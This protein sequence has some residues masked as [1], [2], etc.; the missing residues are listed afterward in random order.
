MT[1]DLLAAPCRWAASFADDP[2]TIVAL[3]E[4]ALLARERGDSIRAQRALEF[5]VANDV[6][7]A[8]VH[9][10]ARFWQSLGEPYTATLLLRQ[11]VEGRTTV[12]L[13]N[14]L[15][16]LCCAQGQLQDAALWW[17]RAGS[18][19]FARAEPSGRQILH[20]LGA[21]SA[22]FGR[23]AFRSLGVTRASTLLALGR[24]HHEQRWHDFRVA[25]YA[26]TAIDTR[27]GTVRPRWSDVPEFA[28]GN[29]GEADRL[30]GPARASQAL[31]RLAPEGRCGPPSSGR[32]VH[33]VTSLDVGGL[34]LR[35]LR[36]I[37]R[38]S[39]PASHTVVSCQPVL[40]GLHA[41]FLNQCRALGIEVLCLK[42]AG[43]CRDIP[44]SD[45]EQPFDTSTGKELATWFDME[46][47]RV[48][49]RL[50]NR[51][52]PFEV[53]VWGG[54]T[55]SKL[56]P[57]LWLSD[58]PRIRHE[59]GSLLLA[60]EVGLSVSGWARRKFIAALTVSGMCNSRFTVV[61][62][63]IAVWDN[64]RLRFKG[65]PGHARPVVKYNRLPEEV[66]SAT[67]GH[68][69]TDIRAQLRIPESHLVI[70]YV[71][72][73]HPVKNM[74]L[75]LDAAAG[76]A[77]TDEDVSFLIVGDGSVW[78]A[79]VERA[80]ELGIASRCRFVGQKST[81]IRSWYGVID[82]L[83]FTSDVEGLSNTLLEAQSLGIPVI[84]RR[85]GGTGEAVFDGHTGSLVE[86][87]TASAITEAAVH[88]LR[89]PALRL[90]CG[91][92][93]KAYVRALTS[94]PE[95]TVAVAR[96]RLEELRAATRA[97]ANSGRKVASGR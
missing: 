10:L 43:N 80:V 38:S 11:A 86:S 84:S 69:A 36:T 62:N 27:Y 77:R 73:L 63:S 66:L 25:A 79:S 72:R 35:M 3:R 16:Q 56:A 13:C 20:W 82:I 24:A 96:R 1:D 44:V 5:C 49:L 94:L 21:Y 37:A 54:F 33:F 75:W 14:H 74:H 28:A 31:D 55:L 52:A 34:E 32:H 78:K 71:A 58:V 39:S 23:S 60:Y 53:T 90:H 29:A 51:E 30:S 95:A 85:A 15:A 59:V 2:A 19:V 26:L 47:N 8:S 83:L 65:L 42:P 46:M 18:A 41:D 88:M 40:S 93:G 50:L 9:A 57:A 6:G 45:D 81:D 17:C 61:L 87:A 70:G 91:E 67:A 97:R 7:E 48:A 12:W 4:Q 64:L 76:I 92:A 89:S 22:A 68:S